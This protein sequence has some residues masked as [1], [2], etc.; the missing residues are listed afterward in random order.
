LVAEQCVSDPVLG[1]WLLVME[2]LLLLR[3]V[4]LLCRLFRLRWFS[5]VLLRRDFAYI[6]RDFADFC[7]AAPCSYYWRFSYCRAHLRGSC[8]TCVCLAYAYLRILRLSLSRPFAWLLRHLRQRTR[9]LRLRILAALSVALCHLRPSRICV[10]TVPS[11]NVC[12]SSPRCLLC[13]LHW[14]RPRVCVP[15]TA[16][17]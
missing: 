2:L 12:V 14:L 3:S 8:V 15:L 6:R 4:R 17:F 5:C 1:L 16:Y 11:C 10:V 9:V 13:R 7:V